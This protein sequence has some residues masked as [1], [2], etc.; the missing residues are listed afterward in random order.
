PV[1]GPSRR[2]PDPSGHSATPP[3][4]PAGSPARTARQSRGRRLLSDPVRPGHG[5]FRPGPRGPS[6]PFVVRVPGG[7]RLRVRLVDPLLVALGMD[8]AQRTPRARLA[9][10]LAADSLH[11][12]PV[13]AAEHLPEWTTDH[14]GGGRSQAAA[15]V[16]STAAGTRRDPPSWH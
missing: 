5:L 1:R 10:G 9:H 11:T 13:P 2:D 6:P 12:H 3:P 4:S 8:D 15:A 7:P 14:S 16:W